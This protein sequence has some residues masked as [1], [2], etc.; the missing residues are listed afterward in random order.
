VAAVADTVASSTTS[1][2]TVTQASLKDARA[3]RRRAGWCT[4]PLAGCFRRVKGAPRRWVVADG[5][6]F[7]RRPARGGH[8]LHFRARVPQLHT[9][10][11]TPPTCIADDLEVNEASW[12]VSHIDVALNRLVFY[13]FSG[14]NLARCPRKPRR[15]E[16][17]IRKRHR[18]ASQDGSGVGLGERAVCSILCMTR[19][20]SVRV[21]R[22]FARR[23][24][25]T[26]GWAAA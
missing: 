17:R 24:S 13:H 8:T 20:E 5:A 10:V 12:I 23:P 14:A 21:S 22:T 6:A 3:L 4:T 9:R 18:L 25:L 15:F 19:R 7:V 1:P 2:P 11:A 16:C 26:F